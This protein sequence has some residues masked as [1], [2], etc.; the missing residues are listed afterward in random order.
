MT[1]SFDPDALYVAL[2][3]K[4][5]EAGIRWRDVAKQAGVSASTLT[6]IGQFKRPDADGVVRLL[7]W[8]G[9][10]DLAP[11]IKHESG[12]VGSQP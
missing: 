4:R 5:R 3:R 2:D 12:T 11:F 10:T 8:L 9:T 1:A 7:A 6:R